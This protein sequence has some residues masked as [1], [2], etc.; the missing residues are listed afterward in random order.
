MI[1]MYI[2]I[3][4]TGFSSAVASVMSTASI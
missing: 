2:R 3:V 1:M 4:D